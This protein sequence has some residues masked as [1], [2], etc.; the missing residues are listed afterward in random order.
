MC[1]LSSTSSH[2]HSILIWLPVLEGFL[3]NPCMIFISLV[4]CFLCSVMTVELYSVVHLP[5]YQTVYLLFL[6]ASV[7]LF[8]QM[9]CQCC[10]VY[11][12]MKSVRFCVTEFVHKQTGIFSISVLLYKNY[13]FLDI[14]LCGLI[15]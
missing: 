6:D 2:P 8:N 14:L 12:T 7:S 5:R 3:Q 10:F 11:S 9:L 15:N 4:P 1:T 13:Q